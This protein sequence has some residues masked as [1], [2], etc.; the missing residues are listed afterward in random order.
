MLHWTASA[1]LSVALS[2]RCR[3]L[4][5]ACVVIALLGCASTNWVSVRNVPRNPLADQ[6]KLLSRG[7]PEPTARTMQFLRRYDLARDLNGD[8]RKLLAKVQEV[9]QREPS[10]DGYQ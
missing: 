1:N 10:P 9:A 6:L 3:G 4:L 8:S 7:G 5:L 2:R